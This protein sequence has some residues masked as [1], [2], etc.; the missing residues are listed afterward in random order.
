MVSRDAAIEKF[1]RE[2]G[3]RLGRGRSSQSQGRYSNEAQ[4]AGKK[5]ADNVDIS[6]VEELSEE[7]GNSL[8]KRHTIELIEPVARL[9]YIE[10]DTLRVQRIRN[11]PG[12]EVLTYT[13]EG[14]ERLL[15]R[16][17]FYPW[18]NISSYRMDTDG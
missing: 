1:M 9:E 12:I 2:Q 14:R 7:G 11:S 16:V 18:H 3:I 6:V 15:H 4:A 13:M 5:A 17:E 10:T 8:A